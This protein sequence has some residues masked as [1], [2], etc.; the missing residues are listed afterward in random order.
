MKINR[1]PMGIA[2]ALWGIL[3]I[4]ILLIAAVYRLTP[5]AVDTFSYDL[6][7]YHILF[8][9]ISIV[10]MAFFEGYMG[11]QRRFS[12]RVASRARYLRDNPRTDLIILAPFFCMSYFHAPLKRKITSVSLTIFIILMIIAVRKLSQP[13]K[14]IVDAG[15]V[16]GLIW[17]IISIAFY[18]YQAFTQDIFDHPPEVE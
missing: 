12:P 18:S 17:G 9:L 5:F 14:G 2:G 16:I 1:K 8:L 11:F 10:F 7:W 3:G 13:W 4:Q 6:H 15:V